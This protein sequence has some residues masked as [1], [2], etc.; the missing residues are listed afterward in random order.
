MDELE[1]R[2][3]YRTNICCT[4]ME[5]EGEGWDPVWLAYRRVIHY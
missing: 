5:T 2:Y 1:D 4:T 3:T